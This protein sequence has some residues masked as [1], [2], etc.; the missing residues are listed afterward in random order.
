MK[1]CKERMEYQKEK[2]QKTECTL[3]QEWRKRERGR[4]TGRWKRRVRMRNK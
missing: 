2:K 4:M 3:L 1:N